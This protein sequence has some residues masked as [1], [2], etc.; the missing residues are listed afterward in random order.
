V[1]AFGFNSV[2]YWDYTQGYQVKLN[3]ADDISWSGA[4]IPAD[5]DIPM[6][7]GWNMI[8]YCPTYALDASADEFYV[9][10]PIIERVTIAKEGGGKFMIP[11]FNFSNM[12][13][14]S[15]GFGY[16]VKLNE[17]GDDEIIL[18]YPEEQ[19]DGASVGEVVSA[20]DHWTAPTPTDANMSVLITDI[21]GIELAEGDQ[22]AAFSSSN[23][24]IGVGSIAD[25]RSGFAVWAD[26]KGTD[27]TEGALEGEAF[28][29]RL[30]DA[31]KSAE[32]DLEVTAIYAGKGLEFE[33]D[34]FVALEV[35]V[36]AMIPDEYSL[37][38][39]FPNPFN[40]I[41]KFAFGLSEDTEVSISVFDVSGRLV[42]TLVNGQL[43]AGTHVVSWA[44]QNNAAGLY[45]VKMETLSGF[46]S[47]KKIALLK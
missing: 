19:E 18:N 5:G 35:S 20:G 12:D 45:L 1:P 17:E 32:R 8:G 36:Q 33:A 28:T 22:I 40:S 11:A 13:P 3:D 29:L 42:T 16:Q 27:Q 15:E 38:Q 39:N 4:A 2:P 7:V 25:S 10:S 26:E 41:T 34:A 9:L 43:Q 31:D 46:N 6:G 37:S 23:I 47:V 14:W 30:W 44:G 24:Q 21:N